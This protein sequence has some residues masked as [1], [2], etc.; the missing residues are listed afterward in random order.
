MF[1]AELLDI[2]RDQGLVLKDED[3]QSRKFV[4]HQPPAPNGGH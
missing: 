2:H 3:T 4:F 1:A